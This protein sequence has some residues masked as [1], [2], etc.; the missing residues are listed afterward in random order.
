MSLRAS[1]LSI[2]MTVCFKS[3]VEQAGIITRIF[4]D[5]GRVRVVVKPAGDQFEG[6]Y[7][8]DSPTTVLDI[9]Q[10]WLE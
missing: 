2:G 1:D 10:L 9:D 4:R 3:D 6:D 8:T 5:Y 7:L